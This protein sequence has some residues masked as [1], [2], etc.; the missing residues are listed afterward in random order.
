MKSHREGRLG[1]QNKTNF[2]WK[3]RTFSQVSSVIHYNKGNSELSNKM[4]FHALPIKGYRREIASQKNL[5]TSTR[6]QR[7]TD[8]QDAPGMTVVN[9]NCECSGIDNVIDITESSNKSDTPCNTCNESLTK[10]HP[11]QRNSKY[12]QTL[13]SQDNARRRVRSSGMIRPRYNNTRNGRL[14]GYVSAKE[15]MHSRN[16]TFEQNQYTNLRVGTKGCKPGSAACKENV[17]AS[18]TIQYCGNDSET[19]YVPVYYKPNNAKYAKQGSVDASTKLLQ[20][21]YDT[22]TDHGN[23]LYDAYGANTANALAYGVPGNGYTIKDKVGYPN[24]CTPKFP[25]GYTCSSN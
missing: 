13:S 17:Y 7:I 24:I 9:G 20:L 16:K 8:F 21:K 6:T 22:I 23:T 1:L 25:K 5:K 14:D 19:N 18:N 12:I 2:K 4:L 15:Y 10:D 3:G 11:E